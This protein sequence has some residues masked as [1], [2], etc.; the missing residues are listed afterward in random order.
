MLC[1]ALIE[2]LPMGVSEL[3]RVS[4]R[5]VRLSPEAEGRSPSTMAMTE[6]RAYTDKWTGAGLAAMVSMVVK[7][8]SFSHEGFGKCKQA[9][10]NKHSRRNWR[11]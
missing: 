4:L 2:G 10:V 8:S 9:E 3:R 11:D 1:C 7:E 5:E 6:M